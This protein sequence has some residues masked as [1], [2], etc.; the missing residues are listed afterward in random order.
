MC[1]HEEEKK[2]KLGNSFYSLQHSALT[3]STLHGENILPYILG[4]QIVLYNIPML[5]YLWIFQLNPLK[6]AL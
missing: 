1:S 2:N 5:A 4:N 6:N 3:Y